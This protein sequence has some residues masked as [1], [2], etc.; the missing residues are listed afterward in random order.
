MAAGD[1]NVWGLEDPTS[2]VAPLLPTWT[3]GRNDSKDAVV[4]FLRLLFK[5]AQIEWF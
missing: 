5:V 4:S 2:E 1:L 3:R